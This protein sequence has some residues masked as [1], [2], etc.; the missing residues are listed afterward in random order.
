[1]QQNKF[2]T[3]YEYLKKHYEQILLKKEDG[4]IVF[5]L[6]EHYRNTE[7]G[8]PEPSIL[9]IIQQVKTE[10]GTFSDAREQRNQNYD[11]LKLLKIY[12]LKPNKNKKYQ[13][14]TL[15]TFAINFCRGIENRIN[16]QFEPSDVERSIIDLYELLQ[17]KIDDIKDF[18]HWY[19]T[20]FDTQKDT[21]E[22]QILGLKEQIDITTA[23]LSTIIRSDVLNYEEKID[24]CNDKL[25]EIE[26]Q[27]TALELAFAHNSKIQECLESSTL[28]SLDFLKAK[29]NVIDFITY[30]ADE[31]SII[32]STIQ[33]IKPSVYRLLKDVDK[34]DYD[35]RL[36][37]FV[38]YIFVNSTSKSKGWT[39]NKDA[40][41]IEIKLPSDV[42][43]PFSISTIPKFIRIDPR[44]FT[45]EPDTPNQSSQDDIEKLLTQEAE[46]KEKTR[47]IAKTDYWVDRIES[48][49]YE[50]GMICFTDYF[51][52]I[53][54]EEHGDAEIGIRT[55]SKLL[56]Q[57]SKNE[58]ISIHINDQPNNQENNILKQ[59]PNIQIWKMSITHNKG[60]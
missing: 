38:Q 17:K 46:G 19:K 6:Y 34:R 1:M 58:Q 40:F 59:Y 45:K 26:M 52:L 5:Y 28:Q 9:S 42:S 3:I 60:S 33:K 47:I 39:S 24:A 37:K 41:N 49:L 7:E 13:R 53:L 57:F 27:A 55:A 2:A 31:L 35:I 22:E 20:Q 51:A 23:D 25:T 18:S 36:E 14:Y 10:L 11:T 21:L 15:T 48:D 29:Q 32:N 43:I 44:T 4:L 56:K 12:F 8:I 50:K 54:E 16:L 30:V